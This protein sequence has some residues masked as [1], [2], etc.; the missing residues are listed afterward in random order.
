MKGLDDFLERDRDRELFDLP[1]WVRLERTVRMNMFRRECPYCGT[2][3]VAFTILHEARYPLH[4]RNEFR[5]DTFATCGYCRRGVV[6]TFDTKGNKPPKECPPGSLILLNTA[7]EPPNTGA[8]THTPGNVALFFE[9]AM[10]NLPKN[11]D[12]AGSMFRKALD[13]GLKSKFPE[14]TGKMSARINE[15]AAQQKLT[16]ELAEWAH[17]IR[18]DGNDAAHEE[19]PFEEEDAK[20]LCDFTRLV[21]YYLFTLPGMLEKSQ[22]KTGE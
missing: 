7:P 14:I 17:Q 12:A 19:E 6:A 16:P 1:P 11:W 5:W 3:S 15:A 8:P 4:L 20:K 21:F 18:L 13:T 10:D 22:N 9:Q 2:K